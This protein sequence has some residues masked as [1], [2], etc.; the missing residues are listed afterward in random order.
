MIE[1]LTNHPGATK[2]AIMANT[3]M[4]LHQVNCSVMALYE[5]VRLVLIG[6]GPTRIGTY[7]LRHDDAPIKVATIKGARVVHAGRLLLKKYG[8]ASPA[9]RKS[10]NRGVSSGMGGTIYD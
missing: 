7:Y 3:G 10:E 8:Y 1:Y 9:L 6:K 2:I 4:T 5:S